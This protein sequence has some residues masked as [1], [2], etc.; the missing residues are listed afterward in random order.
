M[1]RITAWIAAAVAL[2]VGGGQPA[3]PLV[4]DI[5]VEQ[6][7]AAGDRLSFSLPVNPGDGIK[8]AVDQLG[9]DVAVELAMNGATAATAD[10][11]EKHRYGREILL[12]QAPAAGTIVLTV[13]GKTAM[14]AGGRFR[15][16][17]TVYPG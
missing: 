9:V 3:A 7:I 1:I 12:W 11:R 8:V 13:R 6:P 15:L 17:A 5:P 14:P 2:I 10:E 4:P 16:L